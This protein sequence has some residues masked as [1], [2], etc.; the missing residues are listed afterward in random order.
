[1]Y[2]FVSSKDVQL[3]DLLFYQL[4]SLILEATE[5]VGI[6]LAAAGFF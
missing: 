3:S 5:T 2:C 6:D 4:A 1:M